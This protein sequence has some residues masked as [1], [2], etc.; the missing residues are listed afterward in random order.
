[1][2]PYFFKSFIKEK[3]RGSI[4]TS[5]DYLALCYGELFIATDDVGKLA[6]DVATREIDV[7]NI[8]ADALYILKL[9]ELIESLVLIHKARGVEK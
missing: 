1:L 3:G 7:T 9:L 4:I 2:Q 8:L 6:D 5:A